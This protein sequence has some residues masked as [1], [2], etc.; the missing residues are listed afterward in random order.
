MV[1]LEGITKQYPKAPL[2]VY[3]H[4]NLH[5]PENQ[6][7]ALMG[8]SGSGKTTLLYILGL[9]DSPCHG[10]YYFEGKELFALTSAEKARFRNAHLG[11][12][13][14]AHLLIPHL[15]V[16][17]NLMLPLLYRGISPLEAKQRARMQLK[18]LELAFLEDRLPSQLSGGQQQRV[19]ILRALIGEPK[20]LLADEPTSALDDATKQEILTILFSLQQKLKFSMVIATHDATI[21]KRC[22]KLLM[23]GL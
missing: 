5:L 12:V 15:S 8:S 18:L 7:M 14:Q 11:F 4:F 6:S 23:V 19:A 13:F 17:Q 21:A 10:H 2:P 3:H 20:L 22:D 16:L 9:L 1:R